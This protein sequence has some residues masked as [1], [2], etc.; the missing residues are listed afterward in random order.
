M[1]ET[2]IYHLAAENASDRALTDRQI[3]LRMR[4]VEFHSKLS[5]LAAWL[6][7]D[8]GPDEPYEW[9][10]LSILITPGDRDPEEPSGLEPR[11]A[12]WP[13]TDLA[14]LGKDHPQGGRAVISGADLETL[15]PLV[16][17][18]DTLTLWKSGGEIYSIL[19]RPLLPDE[20]E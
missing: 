18:A 2:S 14:T 17:Q 4:V 8:L 3:E 11:I 20:I 5:D 1:F 16:Q 9:Q 12:E 6:A 10:A 19:L 13:L 7:D 15:R